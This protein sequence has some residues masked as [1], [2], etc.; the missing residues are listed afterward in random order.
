MPTTYDAGLRGFLVEVVLNSGVSL[1]ASQITLTAQAQLK[2]MN[3]RWTP[4][5]MNRVLYVLVHRSM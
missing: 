4:E 1:Q 5:L 2:V 3:Y